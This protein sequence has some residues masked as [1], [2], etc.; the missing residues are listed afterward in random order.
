METSTA[1]PG[2]LVAHIPISAGLGHAT[3]QDARDH[4]VKVRRRAGEGWRTGQVVVA[5]A[6][7]VVVGATHM[8]G[9]GDCGMC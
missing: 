4:A 3:S 5:A 8:C 7:V 9:G 6:A 1:H 2:T